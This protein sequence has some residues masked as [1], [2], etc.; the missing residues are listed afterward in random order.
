M[1]KGYLDIIKGKVENLRPLSD[2]PFEDD[3]LRNIESKLAASGF[4]YEE[5]ADPRLE[6]PRRVKNA[7]LTDYSGNPIMFGTVTLNISANNDSDN[8]DAI[9]LSAHRPLRVIMDYRGS[10][11]Q[12][13]IENTLV[14]LLDN[15]FIAAAYSL[16]WGKAKF[17]TEHTWYPDGAVL[18]GSHPDRKDRMVVH[19]HRKDQLAVL[20]DVRLPFVVRIE[21]DAQPYEAL[22]QLVVLASEVY[23]EW[24]A[25]FWTLKHSAQK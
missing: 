19:P 21:Q 23:D 17:H 12:P 22:T 14:A 3:L 8:I 7:A 15:G 20:S 25:P 6:L 5:L 13:A 2:M 4:Q 16:N 10:E 9:L 1:I 24:E 11:L 18:F